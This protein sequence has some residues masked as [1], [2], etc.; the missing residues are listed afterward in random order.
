M[1]CYYT[2]CDA[3]LMEIVII[4]LVKGLLEQKQNDESLCKQKTSLPNQ[5]NYALKH[6]T[7]SCFEKI[8]KLHNY[9][10]NAAL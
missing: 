5:K 2:N 6:S 8:R 1:A 7:E 4:N 3:I 10:S 9:F